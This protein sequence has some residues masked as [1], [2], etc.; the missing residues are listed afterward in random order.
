MTLLFVYGSLKE[1]YPNFHIN[2]G[3][4][5]PGRFQT[6]QPYPFY[7]AGGKLPCLL[8]QPG[9]GVNVV[10]EVYRVSAQALQAMDA[11]ERLGEPGGYQRISIQVRP[12]PTSDSDALSVDV[13][14]Q[15]PQ[16]LV[17]TGPHVG[18]IAEYT[19]EHAKH[20]AW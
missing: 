20:L 7:L 11:L 8:N 4:R 6:V 5:V 1:G 12:L 18:P 9:Q 16:I 17:G 19:H 14:V 2:Q 13:Y 10:G 3:Q 15:Q